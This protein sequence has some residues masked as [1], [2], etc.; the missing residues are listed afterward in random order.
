M[1]VSKIDAVLYKD[2][3]PG[4]PVYIRRDG[5]ITNYRD[6]EHEF[7]GKP[8]PKWFSREDAE[9]IAQKEGLPFREA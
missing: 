1:K 5:E 2:E 7:L 6:S 4:G 8:V 9:A 3:G